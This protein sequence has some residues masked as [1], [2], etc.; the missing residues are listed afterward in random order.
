MHE[1]NISDDIVTIDVEH[2][3][4]DDER[5]K[6]GAELSQLTCDF[7]RIDAQRKDA[8]RDFAEELKEIRA[9]M[10]RVAREMES[11]KRTEK[12][13]TVMSVDLLSN[14]RIWR[15]VDTNEV[16]K[17]RDLEPGEEAQGELAFADRE[18]VRGEEVEREE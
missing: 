17:E 18:T 9:R 5:L 15:D 10:G 3:L 13:D 12:R 1:T 2:E 14:K 6:L 16:V 7:G 8:A 11:G 4:T